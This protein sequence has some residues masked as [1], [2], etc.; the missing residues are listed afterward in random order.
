MSGARKVRQGDVGLEDGPTTT[1]RSKRWALHFVLTSLM[2]I[3]LTLPWL[4]LGYVVT[5][6]AMALAVLAVNLMSGFVGRVALGHGAFVGMGAYIAV[7]LSA[8]HGWPLLATIPVASVSGFVVGVVIAMPAL[9]IRGLHLALVT[10]AFGASFGP[11]VKRFATLTNGANGKGTSASWVAPTWIGEGR[12][13]NVRWVYLVV[14]GIAALVF[15]GVRNLTRGRVGRSL[16]ALRDND[17]AAQSCGV[18]VNRYTIAMFGVSAAVASIAG[19]L[20]VLKQPFVSYE[21]FETSFSLHLFAA[22]TFGGL[23]SVWGAWIGGATLVAVP[24]VAGRL[25]LTVD[26]DVLF[27]ALLIL[28]VVAFPHGLAGAM[29]E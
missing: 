25:G 26:A 2:V 8:D 14:L 16:V 9:R 5:A 19:V 27:G 13:A 18:P 22:A 12:D 17:L 29:A 20:L 1:S 10:L 28:A 21:S 11:L 3:P 6:V 7:I 24:Y 4:L 15:W 23:A